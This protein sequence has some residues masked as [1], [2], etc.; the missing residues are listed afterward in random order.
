MAKTRT[1]SKFLSE[2]P[3]Y[4]PGVYKNTLVWQWAQQVSHT[5]ADV[6]LAA[7]T[8]RKR[9]DMPNQFPHTTALK[10]YL[11]KCRLEPRVV[12]RVYRHLWN[13]Y[14]A[15]RDLTLHGVDSADPK[16][17]STEDVHDR[18]QPEEQLTAAQRFLS[19]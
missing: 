8:V 3:V 13:M 15:Y 12:E 16:P 2:R 4:K 7:R 10:N 9:M 5:D 1:K 17:W 6:V 11:T 18:V 19:R 14:A